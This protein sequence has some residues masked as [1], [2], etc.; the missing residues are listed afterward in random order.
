MRF[1]TMDDETRDLLEAGIEMAHAALGAR[2]K[3]MDPDGVISRSVEM[4]KIKCG[5]ALHQLRQPPLADWDELS[6]EQRQLFEQLI[7]M[8]MNAGKK[9]DLNA[10]WR[11]LRAVTLVRA[12]NDRNQTP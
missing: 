9:D 3:R 8:F 4:S 1:I 12:P 2:A 6:E 7:K 11:K 10:I 5:G